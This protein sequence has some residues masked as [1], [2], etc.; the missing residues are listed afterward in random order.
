MLPATTLRYT[1]E[2]FVGYWRRVGEGQPR[3]NEKK[4]E[5]KGVSRREGEVCTAFG[6]DTNASSRV[7]RRGCY[8]GAER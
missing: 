5:R 7:R 2:E 3:E 6:N 4:E 8:F 1:V